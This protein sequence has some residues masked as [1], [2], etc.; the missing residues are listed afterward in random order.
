MARANR[1]LLVV[2]V[3]SGLA[4][5]IGTARVRLAKVFLGEGSAHGEWI[6]GHFLRAR[7]D[8]GDA[9][10]Q[11]AV[12]VDAADAVARVFARVVEAG[13]F[14]LGT[15]AVLGALRLARR[16]RIS[17]VTP[18]TLAERHMV[19][20]QVALRILP[21]LGAG[22]LASEFDAGVVVAAVGVAVAFVPTAGYRRAVVSRLAL[23][24]GYIIYNLAIRIGST[25]T[26]MT[27][28]LWIEVPAMLEGV[29]GVTWRTCA[30]GNV[31][32]GLAVSIRPAH[33]LAGIH[34]PL[35]LAS[36]VT[37]ALTTVQALRPDAVVER[38]PR[39][40]LQARAD[41]PISDRSAVGVMS[42]RRAAT[43]R[44]M[45]HRKVRLHLK[46]SCS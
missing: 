28:L 25:G 23:A 22:V 10:A 9:V 29:T 43:H 15:V 19:L 12:G 2:P 1:A 24:S 41:R 33:S 44:Y 4:L 14:R 30:R 39:I 20:H 17:E 16:Q 36:Q 6:A 11:F 21:A 37:S 38:I 18:W 8:R 7:A 3:V 34:A 42:A 31:V 40:P 32:P 5:R 45:R 46:R 13:R 26:G 35:V 27:K